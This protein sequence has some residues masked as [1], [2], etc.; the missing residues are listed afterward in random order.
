[1]LLVLFEKLFTVPSSSLCSMLYVKR[2]EHELKCFGMAKDCYSDSKCASNTPYTTQ[3]LISL[4]PYKN[5]YNV[6]E[7]QTVL[8]NFLCLR[9]VT[10]KASFKHSSQR[11][12]KLS[13]ADKLK[14]LGPVLCCDPLFPARKLYYLQVGNVREASFAAGKLWNPTLLI[15]IVSISV[16]IDRRSPSSSRHLICS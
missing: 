16:W 15:S 5:N 3:F 2:G 4:L 7:R 1:M 12:C 6:Q 14:K 11:H 8:A 9:R 10:D 13:F